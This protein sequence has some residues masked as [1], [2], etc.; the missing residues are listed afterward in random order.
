MPLTKEEQQKCNDL[1]QI[2]ME[3]FTVE[4]IAEVE[5]QLHEYLGVLKKK[6]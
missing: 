1:V 6:R 3:T 4:E 2:L 5:V